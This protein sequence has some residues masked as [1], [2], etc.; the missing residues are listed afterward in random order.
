MYQHGYTTGARNN[1]LLG[2]ARNWASRS[3]THEQRRMINREYDDLCHLIW[4]L[5]INS[6]PEEIVKDYDDALAMHG[7][8]RMDDEGQRLED[9]FSYALNL[10]ATRYG[11]SGGEMAPPQAIMSSNYAR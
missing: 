4:N 2:Y 8:P 5:V 11:F 10:G 6:M 3:T 1:P 9:G 7:L